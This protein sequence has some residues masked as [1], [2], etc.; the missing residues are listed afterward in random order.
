MN[1]VDYGVP[2][3]GIMPLLEKGGG[4]SSSVDI[5]S[6]YYYEVAYIVSQ[7]EI[8]SL[9]MDMDILT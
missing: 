4:S 2:F 3:T 6:R 7:L 8:P 9:D 5:L 1:L